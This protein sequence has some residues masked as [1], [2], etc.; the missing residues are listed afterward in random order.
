MSIGIS[1]LSN[2]VK[3]VQKSFKYKDTYILWPYYCAILDSI[4]KGTSCIHIVCIPTSPFHKSFAL[5]QYYVAGQHG[6]IGNLA[7][8]ICTHMIILALYYI[9]TYLQTTIGTMDLDH[10]R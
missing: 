9:K 1:T 3:Q 6:P 8:L 4:A 5:I 2:C 7:R 10:V